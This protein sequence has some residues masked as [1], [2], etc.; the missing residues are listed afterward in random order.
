M[1]KV[2]FKGVCFIL[3]VVLSLYSSWAISNNT[4]STLYTVAGIMFSIGMSLLV[5]SNTAGVR[6]TSIKRHIRSCMHDVRNNFIIWFS[7]DTLAYIFFPVKSSCFSVYGHSF[8]FNWPLFSSCLIIFSIF[9]FIVN[10]M[11]IQ[12]LNRD[13]EDQLDNE[14]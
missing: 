2:V 8:T 12:R 11:Q 3:F 10:F 1:K 5:T 14:K 13:I 4:I 7:L 9:Y 6:N